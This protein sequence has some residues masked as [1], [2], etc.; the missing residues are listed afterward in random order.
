M[1]EVLLSTLIEK[2]REAVQSFG[3]KQSTI[4]H[5]DRTWERLKGYFLK[6]GQ[7]TFSEELIV[8]YIS[9]QREKLESG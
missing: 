6:H 5:Y 2:T 1:N 4:R 3:H 9:E 7:K 8:K